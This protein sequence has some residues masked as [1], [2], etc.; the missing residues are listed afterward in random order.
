[1][2][3]GDDDPATIAEAI[4]VVVHDR[5]EALTAMNQ[6]RRVRATMPRLLG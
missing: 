3:A 2:F 6:A 1:L 5:A 4:H